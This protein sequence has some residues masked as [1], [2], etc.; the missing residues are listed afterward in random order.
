MKSL[1]RRILKLEER[2]GPAVET[3]FSRPLRE[4]IE[5][6]RRRLAEAKERGEW[7]GPVH[8]DEREDLAGL[9]VTEILRRG[10]RNRSNES[11]HQ[12]DRPAGG[13]IRAQSATGLF[14]PSAAAPP[15]RDIRHGS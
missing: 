5:A 9:S 14:A 7:S 8:D 10:R 4:R 1:S 13:P 2:F 6:G 11:C 3:A 15:T 12:A